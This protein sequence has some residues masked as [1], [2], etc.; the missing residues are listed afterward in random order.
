MVSVTK[1]TDVHKI[2][3]VLVA[4]P[5][6]VVEVANQAAIWSLLTPVVLTLCLLRLIS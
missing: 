1:R 4:P 3:F 2:A 6:T 5:G